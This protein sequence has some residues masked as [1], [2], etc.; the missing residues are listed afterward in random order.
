[1]NEQ[2]PKAKVAW[3]ALDKCPFYAQGGGQVTE[4]LSL[5]AILIL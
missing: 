3:I 5:C 2:E 1:M 4:P